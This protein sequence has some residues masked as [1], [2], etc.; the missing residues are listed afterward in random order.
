MTVPFE[1]ST[2]P[3]PEF[4][5]ALQ[6]IVELV[7][8]IMNADVASILGYSLI[9]GTV[10]WKAA[11]GFTVPVDYS[12]PVFRPLGSE[13][14]RRAFEAGTVGIIQ[15]IG[16]RPEFA[17]KEFPVHLA[18][19]ISNMA[20]A[21]LRI[22]GSNSGALT[23]GYRVPHQFTDD[24]KVL[25]KNLAEIATVVLDSERLVDTVTAA[26]KLWEQTFEAI[27]EGILVCDQQTVKQR[28]GHAAVP[29]LSRA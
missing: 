19:G 29:R 21:P 8:R 7:R 18:E 23:A 10:R 15:G 5:P 22:V 28:W 12:Q 2:D 11:S 1:T 25:L 3:R 27:G 13:I 20:V 4:A 9:D 17:E 24:E 6:T 16:S 26:E 14:A